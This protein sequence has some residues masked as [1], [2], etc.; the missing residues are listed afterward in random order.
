[1]AGAAKTAKKKNV[2]WKWS[3]RGLLIAASVVLNIGFIVVVIT[4]MSSHAL[5][6]FFMSQGLS[7]YCDTAN[8]SAFSSNSQKTQ[9]LRDYTCARGDAS[10]YF[11][12]GFKSYLNHLHISG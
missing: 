8:D 2:I 7:R 1:M 11:Q 4:M 6:Y 9:A 10:Q 5:D 3:W 12:D